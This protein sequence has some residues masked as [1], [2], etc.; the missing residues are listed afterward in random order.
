VQRGLKLLRSK[1]IGE[2]HF[3]RPAFIDERRW[4]VFTAYFRDGQSV[5]GIGRS[6]GLSPSCVSRMLYDVDARLESARRA[7]PE[8]TPVGLES[9][10]EELALSPR[11]LNVLH[12]LGCDRVRDVL[13]RDL[14][15]VPGMG[16]KTRD[17][18]YAAL[19]RA[20]FPLLEVEQPL[21]SEIRNLDR[22]LLRMH[23]RISTALGTVTKEIALLQKRLQKRMEMRDSGLAGGV[24]AARSARIAA[25]SQG[26]ERRYQ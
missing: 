2:Q 26:S 19:R 12:S 18:V 7:E 3:P 1:Y 10:I 8:G 15:S 4:A 17:E 14:S 5:T 11:A 25:T 16:P 21:D 24:V 9:R 13:E 22:S 6:A 23:D 20:G